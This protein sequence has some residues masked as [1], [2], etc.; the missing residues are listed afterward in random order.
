MNTYTVYST[1]IK[2]STFEVTVC[3]GK[4]NYINVRKTSNNPFLL[5]GR[6]FKN[7]DLAIQSYKSPEMKTFLLQIEMGLIQSV[8][9]LVA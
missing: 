9:E 7:F 3:S 2:G 5:A 4:F 1:T 8:R 6:D